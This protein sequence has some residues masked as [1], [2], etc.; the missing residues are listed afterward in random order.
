MRKPK[1]PGSKPAPA[2]TP[3]PGGRAW[4]RVQQ[5]ALARGLPTQAMHV[6]EKVV[7]PTVAGKRQGVK[8]AAKKAAAKSK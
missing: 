2:E 1:L 4:E 7:T 5:F 8:R 6:Q 3:P